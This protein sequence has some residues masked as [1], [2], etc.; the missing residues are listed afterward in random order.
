MIKE[1]DSHVWLLDLLGQEQ[2]IA[3]KDILERQWS[4]FSIMPEGLLDG[5]SPQDVA[6]LI[7]YLLAP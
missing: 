4:E 7:A 1:S 2:V 5:R 6:D 3:K